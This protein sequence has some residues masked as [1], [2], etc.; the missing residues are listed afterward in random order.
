V[1]RTAGQLAP[2]AIAAKLLPGRFHNI[3]GFAVEK[4]VNIVK[5]CVGIDSVE[6]LIDYRARACGAGDDKPNRHVTRMFP[7]RTQEVLNGGSLYW[8]IKGVIRVRQKILALEEIT[9][10]DGIRRC[11]I[12]MDPKLVRTIPAQ[13]RPFQG[14]RY[15]EPENAPADLPVQKTKEDELPLEMQL[16]LAEIG[17][18]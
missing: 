17:L 11:A 15:L 12:V 13:R 6:H 3:L 14:W 7:R 10:A 16:A 8:V 4:H 5:L 1:K 2:G 18:R 9:G